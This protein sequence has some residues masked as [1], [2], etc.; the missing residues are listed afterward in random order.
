M[1]AGTGQIGF[2]GKHPAFGDFVSARVDPDWRAAFEVWLTAMLA[3]LRETLAGDWQGFYDG[4]RPLRFWIGGEVLPGLGACRGVLIAS[5][6][7]VGRRFPFVMV[8]QGAQGT[9]PPLDT[10]QAFYAQAV[11]FAQAALTQRV[12]RPEDLL[13]GVGSGDSAAATPG[14]LWA[15]NPSQDVAEL[16]GDI[17]VVDHMRAAAGRTY[18]WTCAQGDVPSAVWAQAGL[19]DHDAIVWVATSGAKEDEARHDA[20]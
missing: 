8:E 16:L 5:R 14:Q 18:W 15:T 11:D 13:A 6:D 20:E 17:A 19:P 10:D 4:L 3:Q 2:L 7:R 12:E 9:P 1:T